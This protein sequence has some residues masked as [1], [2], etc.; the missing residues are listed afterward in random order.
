VVDLSSPS[1]EEESIHDTS[2]NFEF[3]Q[4]LFGELNHAFLGPPSDDK[5]IIL[6]NSE[7]EKEEVCEEKSTSAKNAAAST[8]VNLASTASAADANEDPG[9]APNDNSD[10]LA[11]DPKMGNDNNDRDKVD[12]P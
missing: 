9:A 10:G 4:R 11:L 8:A 3:T 5:I 2:C 1:D 7:E 6:S 12:T